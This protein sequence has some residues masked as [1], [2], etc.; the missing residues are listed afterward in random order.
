MKPS[1]SITPGMNRVFGRKV[2]KT[3]PTCGLNV[4]IYVGRYPK[5][6]PHCSG[7]FTQDEIREVVE[8]LIEKRI[9]LDNVVLPLI[10]E[11]KEEKNANIDKVMQVVVQFEML[12]EL[13]GVEVQGESSNFWLY[14]SDSVDE[15]EILKLVEELKSYSED[16]QSYPS[17][18][19][20]AKWVVSVMN[21]RALKNPSVEGEVEQ[22][23]PTSGDVDVK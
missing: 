8:L 20:G 14:F 23:I 12:D 3:C 16:A 4:P 1:Y 5:R 18:K 21:A 9:S 22:E 6:C 15:E 2:K 7:K 11:K 13:L 17:Q 19:E 10:G